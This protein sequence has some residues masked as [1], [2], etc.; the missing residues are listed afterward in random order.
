MLKRL[1]RL[2]GL[3]VNY[4]LVI[5]ISH[6]GHM[7]PIHRFIYLFLPFMFHTV[8]TKIKMAPSVAIGKGHI[9]LNFSNKVS[10]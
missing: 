9:N 1:D 3:I 6:A 7:D 10:F 5:Y 8:N 2:N 4:T